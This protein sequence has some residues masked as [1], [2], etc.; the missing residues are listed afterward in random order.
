MPIANCRGNWKPYLLKLIYFC[1]KHP[2]KNRFNKH[3]LVIWFIFSYQNIKLWSE[4]SLLVLR[5]PQEKQ[6]HFKM[7]PTLFT[8]QRIIFVSVCM[9]TECMIMRAHEWN[10]GFHASLIVS[11]IIPSEMFQHHFDSLN[12]KVPYKFLFI[13]LQLLNSLVL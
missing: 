11:M 1:L 13:L 10:N 9:M 12:A 7:S 3:V 8:L 6:L 2:Y 4:R 5:L